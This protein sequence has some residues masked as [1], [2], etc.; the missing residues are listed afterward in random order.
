MGKEGPSVRRST[1]VAISAYSSYKNPAWLCI[2]FPRKKAFSGGTRSKR[3]PTDQL[4]VFAEVSI[5]HSSK[6]M[7]PTHK[8]LGRE[9]ETCSILQQH[10]IQNHIRGRARQIASH[11]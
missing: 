6:R 2:S 10:P 8:K 3:V 7:S 4:R 5:G 1:H 11:A 9:R